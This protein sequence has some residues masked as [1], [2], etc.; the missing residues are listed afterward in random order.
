MTASMISVEYW[1]AKEQGGFEFCGD[2]PDDSFIGYAVVRSPTLEGGSQS[3]ALPDHRD[4]L[5]GF[6]VGFAHG[7]ALGRVDHQ[8]EMRSL[9]G[10]VA[11]RDLPPMKGVRN[12]AR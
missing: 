8:N 9:L 2:T 3:F 7:H 1:R 10:F 5:D 11:S 12:A 4:M 6:L